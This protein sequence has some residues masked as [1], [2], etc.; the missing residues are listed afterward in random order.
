MVRREQV[1]G[2]FE[3]KAFAALGGGGWPVPGDK[4]LLGQKTEN[5]FTIGLGLFHPGVAHAA[6]LQRRRQVRRWDRRRRKGF[7]QAQPG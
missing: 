6:Q 7:G 4:T 3:R 2:T 5:G 1:L